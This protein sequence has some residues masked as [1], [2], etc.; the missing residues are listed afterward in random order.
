MNCRSLTPE[1]KLICREVRDALG[2]IMN[3]I[4]KLG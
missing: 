3:R 4:N 2:N 1:Q